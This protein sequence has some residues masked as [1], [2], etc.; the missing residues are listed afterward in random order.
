M[1]IGFLLSI[2][3][4]IPLCD[5]SIPTNILQ[6]ANYFCLLIVYVLSRLTPLLTKQKSMKLKTGIVWFLLEFQHDAR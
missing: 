1:V 3:K 4:K 6:Q 2:F 5:I